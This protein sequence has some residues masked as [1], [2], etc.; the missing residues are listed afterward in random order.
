MNRFKRKTA[1]ILMV[2]LLLLTGCSGGSYKITIGEIDFN[3]DGVSGAY[4]EFNGYQFTSIKLEE[5]DTISFNLEV[6]TEEGNFTVKILDS[7]GDI[8]LSINSDEHSKDLL[9]EHTGTYRIQV[10]GDK[11]E[12][13]FDLVWYVN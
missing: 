13:E 12:G 9:I 1:I 6:T 5:G 11:H 2:I 10:E 3:K 8:I 4:K 7:E